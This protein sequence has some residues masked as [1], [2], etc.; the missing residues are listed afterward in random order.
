MFTG[1]IVSTGKV[2][3]VDF[4]ESD[5]KLTVAPGLLPKEIL[6]AGE[7]ISVNGVCLTLR[8]GN[9]PMKFDVSKETLSRTELGGLSK[10]DVVNL[11][12]ALT[13]AKALGGHLVSGHVDGVATIHSIVEVGLSYVF[14]FAAPCSFA[15]FIAEKGSVTIDGISLTVN[16]VEDQNDSVYFSVNIVPHTL[17]NTNL[18]SRSVGQCVHFEIDQIARYVDRILT[19]RQQET[20]S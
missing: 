17:E 1:I 14:T 19:V 11:E 18:G 15:R 12:P 16:T 10:G 4:L 7:S 20:Q 5:L 2:I 9:I 3:D 13:A 6:A 8:D